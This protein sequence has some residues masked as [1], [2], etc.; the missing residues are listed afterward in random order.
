LLHFFS[1][2][3]NILSVVGGRKHS[4]KDILNVNGT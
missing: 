3:D 1:G 2:P 4:T